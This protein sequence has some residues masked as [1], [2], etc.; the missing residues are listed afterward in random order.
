MTGFTWLN[1][2]EHPR[3]LDNCNAYEF[4]E[5]QPYERSVNETA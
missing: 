4:Q 5:G 2:I 1:I 3:R